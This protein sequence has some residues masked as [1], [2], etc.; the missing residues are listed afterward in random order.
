MFVAIFN[1]SELSSYILKFPKV[2]VRIFR[3]FFRNLMADSSGNK[4]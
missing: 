1:V 2:E 3:P 4:I